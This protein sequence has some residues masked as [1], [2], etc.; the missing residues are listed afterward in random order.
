MGVCV[1]EYLQYSRREG[2]GSPL[3]TCCLAVAVVLVLPV[4]AMPSEVIAAR[5]LADKVVRGEALDQHDRELAAD[6]YRQWQESERV[7][8]A[9]RG[10]PAVG[11]ALQK[12][13]SGELAGLSPGE[14]TA[15]TGIAR[16]ARERRAGGRRSSSGLSG[17]PPAQG[18][19]R[20]GLGRYAV[21]VL[22]GV[23][24]V[25]IV[26]AA[27]ALAMGRRAG[28]GSGGPGA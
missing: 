12:L 15:L 5:R 24:S 8:S 1:V 11:R 13:A 6:A 2:Q 23:V 28:R 25:V 7:P 21:P 4:V 26:V 14:R 18:G 3:R 22:A 17:G 10:D 20:G 9:K 16:N 19:G 27:G